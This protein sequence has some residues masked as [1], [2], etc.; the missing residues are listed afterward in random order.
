MSAPEPPNQPKS[1]HLPRLGCIL[2][3]VFVLAILGA[4]C[5]C[6]TTSALLRGQMVQM[7][8]N[9]RQVYFAASTMA[10]DGF[11]SKNSS[12]AWPGDLA[13]AKEQPITSLAQYVRHLVDHDYLK[14]ADA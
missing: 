11:E 3:V 13:T 1:K 4:L 7:V 6:Q 9:Q 8:N 5:P 2:A 12:L 10:A 14:S